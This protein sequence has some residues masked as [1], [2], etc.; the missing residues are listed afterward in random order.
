M[1]G[2]IS[3]HFNLH[4]H[5]P[6]WK[7]LIRKNWRKACQIVIRQ[8]FEWESY[9]TS[10]ERQVRLKD[11]MSNARSSMFIEKFYR[12]NNYQQKSRKFYNLLLVKTNQRC[13]GSDD[14]AD[15][16]GLKGPGCTPR[17]IQEKMKKLF[18]CFWLVTLGE[19]CL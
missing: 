17:L 5:Q 1:D 12:Q 3:S 11:M 8:S 13:D 14:K 6:M 4:F 7:Q 15:N 9:L 16:S 2:R 18:S 10:K 19:I